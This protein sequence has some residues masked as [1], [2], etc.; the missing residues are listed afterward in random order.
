MEGQ[1]RSST[2]RNARPFCSVF[3]IWTDMALEQSLNRDVKC[4]GGLV[5]ITKREA[6]KDRWFLTNHTRCIISGKLAEMAE[7]GNS[8]RTKHGEDFPSRS[9]ADYK[10]VCAIVDKIQNAMKNP[11]TSCG[12]EVVELTNI[13]SGAKPTKKSAEKI[14]NAYELCKDSLGAV[15]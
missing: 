13:S 4:S 7:L 8:N 6:A 10:A 14:L 3:G 2:K 9:A 15:C 12:S 1:L 5:G 11:L